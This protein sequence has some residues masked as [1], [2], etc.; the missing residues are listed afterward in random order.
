[1]YNEH[2]SYEEAQKLIEQ[3]MQEAEACSRQKQ[4]GFGDSRAA[5]WVFLLVVLL[6][7]AIAMVLF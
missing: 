6:T 1:M 5:R 7:A 2:L 4:L 3:R